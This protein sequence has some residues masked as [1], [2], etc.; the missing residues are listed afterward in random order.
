MGCEPCVP[1]GS[2][3]LPQQQ[4]MGPE[5]GLKGV[6]MA[7]LRSELGRGPRWG[8]LTEDGHALARGSWLDNSGKRG[9]T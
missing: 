1:P 5:E 6:W 9:Q 8:C 2:P 3:S 7:S 4:P